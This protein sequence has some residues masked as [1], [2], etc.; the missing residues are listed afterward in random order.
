MVYGIIWKQNF[1]WRQWFPWGIKLSG[2]NIKVL[3]IKGFLPIRLPVSCLT[4]AP[5]FTTPNGSMMLNVPDARRPF[6]DSTNQNPALPDG[7][8]PAGVGPLRAVPENQVLP[9][10]SAPSSADDD[11]I[12]RKD[13]GLSKLYSLLHKVIQSTPAERLAV[14][15]GNVRIEKLGSALKISTRP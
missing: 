8:Y 6:G 9:E 10:R 13:Y 7:M 11:D 5:K 15:E 14:R 4:T 1:Y 2:H 3:F 12:I